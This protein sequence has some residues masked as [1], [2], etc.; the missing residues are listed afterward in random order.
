MRLL[1]TNLNEKDV[2]PV[3]EQLAQVGTILVSLLVKPEA[4]NSIE[5]V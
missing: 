5:P 1:R 4:D 2:Q 3:K